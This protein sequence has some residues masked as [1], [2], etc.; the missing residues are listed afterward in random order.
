[1][2]ATRRGMKLG[3]AKK[4]EEDT[5]KEELADCTKTIPTRH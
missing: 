3:K 4:T 1:M 2:D 5:K